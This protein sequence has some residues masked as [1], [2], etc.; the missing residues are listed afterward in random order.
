MILHFGKKHSVELSCPNR[1]QI[2]SSVERCYVFLENSFKNSS[3]I[4]KPQMS[5]HVS[6]DLNESLWMVVLTPS[7]GGFRK[8]KGTLSDKSITRES[9]EKTAAAFLVQDEFEP[10]LLP[11]TKSKSLNCSCPL[12]CPL[13]AMASLLFPLLYTLKEEAFLMRHYFSQAQETLTLISRTCKK[14]MLKFFI[15]VN[16]ALMLEFT[17]ELHHFRYHGIFN[18]AMPIAHLSIIC[19]WH[20]E[21]FCFLPLPWRSPCCVFL[22]LPISLEHGPVVLLTF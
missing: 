8:I 22:N 4:D 9:R 20:W 10:R 16:I 6:L 15:P 18:L 21:T 5:L 12:L 1:S 3:L 2:A 14:G 7:P 11:K 17:T 19:T 13:W